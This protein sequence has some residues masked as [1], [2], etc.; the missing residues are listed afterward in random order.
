MPVDIAPAYA[1]PARPR[2]AFRKLALTEARLLL[3]E[4]VALFWGRGRPGHAGQHRRLLAAPVRAGGAG[5]I[6]RGVHRRGGPVL[7]LGLDG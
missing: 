6:R 5:R 3:R 4:P 7:P 1:A 2:P